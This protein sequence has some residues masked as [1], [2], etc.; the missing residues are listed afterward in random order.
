M[1]SPSLFDR[2]AVGNGLREFGER[3]PHRTSD[4]IRAVVKMKAAQSTLGMPMHA[5]SWLTFLGHAKDSLHGIDQ[6]RCE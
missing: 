2:Q 5:V 3:G 1:S 4:L 6:F